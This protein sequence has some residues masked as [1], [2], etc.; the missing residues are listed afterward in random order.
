MSKY[1]NVSVHSGSLG[2]WKRRLLIFAV[3]LQL[4]SL[5]SSLEQLFRINH[6][7]YFQSI[8]SVDM[9]VQHQCIPA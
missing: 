1:P 5:P 9:C 3:A 2:L 8:A 6:A 4:R 7:V